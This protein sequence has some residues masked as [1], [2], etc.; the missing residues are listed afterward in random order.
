MGAGVIPFSVWNGKVHFLFHKTFSGRRAGFLVDFGG[1]VRDGESY[2]QTAIRE[3]VEETDTMFLE[4]DLSRACRTPSRVDAQL[5]IVEALFDRTLNVHPD[6]WCQREPGTR[7]PPKD[8]RTFFIEVEHRDID[9]INR[10]WERDDGTRFKKPRQLL[11]VRAGELAA[12]YDKAPKRLWRRVRQL[13]G[14]RETIAAIVAAKEPA[15]QVNDSKVETSNS[16]S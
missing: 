2:R 11:W 4:P 5:P 13:V 15:S 8:W 3:F 6:W 1:G 16:G 9:E 12:I 14:A 10:E 7:V